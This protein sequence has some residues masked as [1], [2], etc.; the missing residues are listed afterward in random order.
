MIG[1]LLDW[2]RR[3][4]PVDRV[5][6][7]MGAGIESRRRNLARYWRPH[8]AE[9]RRVEAEWIA[10]L[11]AGGSLIVAGAGRLND[12]DEAAA[13]RF[14][15][16]HLLDA[17]ARNCPAW[18]RFRRRMGPG[19]E[20]DWTIADVAGCIHAWVRSLDLGTW[21]SALGSIRR[22][23]AIPADPPRI[24]ADAVLSLSLLS[25]IPIV[26][27]DAV[28]ARLRR[29]FGSRM[30]D[31]RERE[32]LDSVAIGARLL[33]ER[34]L[35]WVR[36]TARQALLIADIEYA[37]YE[38]ATPFSRYRYRPPPVGWSAEEGWSCPDASKVA[39]EPAL[40]GVDLGEPAATWLWHIRP[41]GLESLTEGTVHRVG[42]FRFGGGPAL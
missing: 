3:R 30:V 5:F 20:V 7:S 26:W 35:E 1:Y 11:A 2:L 36:R 6:L 38:G 21:D 12:L 23:A 14:E 8:F 27:Q 10:S 41:L 17:D 37:Y 40:Y 18:K 24:H 16:I 32:W 33:V 13:R 39:V 25:Q 4:D 9:S 42:A 29:R 34:H 31:S 15:R 19:T 22:A 28:E